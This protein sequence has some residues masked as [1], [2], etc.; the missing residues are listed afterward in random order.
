MVGGTPG[1]GY[2][3][4]D[5][6]SDSVQFVDVTGLTTE[7]STRFPR[8]FPSA[9]YTMSVTP[10][11][12]PTLG[13]YLRAYKAH[14]LALAGKLEDLKPGIEVNESG[15]GYTQDRIELRSKTFCFKGA[16]KRISGVSLTNPE[17]EHPVIATFLG[18]K[19]GSRFRRRP[20]PKAFMRTPS[21]GALP[22]S[23]HS[24]G[25]LPDT[26]ILICGFALEGYVM[27]GDSKAGIE[28]VTEIVIIEGLLEEKVSVGTGPK[29][30]SKRKADV[31]MDVLLG[32]TSGKK[33]A[34][35]AVDSAPNTPTKSSAV[36][37]ATALV[38]GCWFSDLP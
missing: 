11:D 31:D 23:F 27:S 2:H 8:H 6:S 29:T 20:W 24:L 10:I 3:T 4:L 25:A 14:N 1:L 38:A 33:A 34:A 28:W 15:I 26:A 5:P 12:E 16:E 18:Q 17:D 7:I 19:D 21:G 30:P 35:V 13:R 37:A 32:L 22:V 36:A 9:K